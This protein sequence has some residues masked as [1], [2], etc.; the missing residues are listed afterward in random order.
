MQVERGNMDGTPVNKMC[1]QC[2]VQ[3][4]Y[5]VS[6]STQ[7]SAM[8]NV[9]VRT[10]YTAVYSACSTH[11]TPSQEFLLSSVEHHLAGHAHSWGIHQM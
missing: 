8:Y 7:Y 4:V 10:Q 11:Q 1:V 5:S 9:S 2:N 3:C 6:V